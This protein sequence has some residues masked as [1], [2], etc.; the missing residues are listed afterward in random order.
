MSSTLENFVK[1]TGAELATR[2]GEFVAHD[3]DE[4]LDRTNFSSMKW[5]AEIA[6]KNDP[7]LLCVG[8]AEMDFK[9]APA[10]LAAIETVAKRGHF[11]YPYKRNSY[12]DAIIGHLTRHFDWRPEREHILSNVGIYPSM[13]PIIEELTLPGDE[14]IFQ[15]PVH[16]IF[17]EVIAAA[18]RVA[19]ANPLRKIGN[20]YEFD[21]E[22]LE[23]AITPKTKML[24]LC[25]PH[26]PVGRVWTKEELT[27][28]EGICSR[29]NIIVIADEVYF[30]LVLPGSQFTPYAKVSKA[31]ASRSISLISASKSFNLTG[32]KHSLVITNNPDFQR[33]YMTG[34]RR[35][36]L[37]FG[38][39]IFGQAATEAAF[40]DADDWSLALVQYIAANQNFLL[41]FIQTRLPWVGVTVAE[42]TYF[43]WLDFGSL[44]GSEDWLKHI[45][46]EEAHVVAT[47][48]VNLG[49]GGAGHVRIN[50]ATQREILHQV[51]NRIADAI[52][53]TSNRSARNSK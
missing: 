21:F 25:S 1:K 33:A 53:R 27:R 23:S 26:N 18:N 47:M 51:L 43:S 9:A 49:S 24:L 14:I 2:K 38:G 42:G 31:A 16:H 50:M 3:F 39:D 41:E 22:H 35:N 40:R 11:G 37:Y 20:K 28:L 52:D 7:S 36:N 15:P 19:L 48:G 17:P 29:H 12:Y 34:L 6:R 13:Q 8:T 32:L 5:E 44:G 10:V 4:P 46:E 30:G 45:L